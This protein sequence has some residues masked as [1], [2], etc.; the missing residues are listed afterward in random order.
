MVR[1]SVETVM[2]IHSELIRAIGG[3]EIQCT[4]EELVTLGWGLADSS[5]AKAELV[6]WIIAHN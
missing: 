5:I 3:I 6:N 1:P 2:T 4:N